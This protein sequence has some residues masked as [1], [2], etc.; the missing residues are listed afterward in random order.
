MQAV[1]R[2]APA[3]AGHIRNNKKFAFAPRCTRLLGPSRFLTDYL[4]EEDANN[5]RGDT[6]ET[7]FTASAVC[8]ALGRLFVGPHFRVL[9]TQMNGFLP[10]C[11]TKP[12]GVRRTFVLRIASPSLPPC[13][14]RNDLVRLARSQRRPPSGMR[15]ASFSSRDRR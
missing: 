13:S 1:K 11:W 15:I 5:E 3:V 9:I 6:Y 2:P 12:C 14:A 8:A 4:A 10:R 7:R